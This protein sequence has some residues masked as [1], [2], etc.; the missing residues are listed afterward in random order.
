MFS[1]QRKFFI[2]VNA[3]NLTIGLH[4]PENG[5]SINMVK[6]INELAFEQLGKFRLIDEGN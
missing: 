5:T 4:E 1:V 3:T 6:C 2:K